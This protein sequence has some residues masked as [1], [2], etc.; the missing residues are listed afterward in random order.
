MTYLLLIY[1]KDNEWA[2][3]TQAEREGI[4]GEYRTLVGELM[5]QGKYKGGHE[6]SPS[7]TA[8]TVRVRGGKRSVTDGPFAETKEQLGGYFEV[9]AADLEEALAIAER[10]PS[11][12]TGSIEVRAVMPRSQP[13]TSGGN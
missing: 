10:I 7:P 5:A 4:Y 3:L 6:L 1:I 2:A 11:A 8:S 12:R 9:E 13:A